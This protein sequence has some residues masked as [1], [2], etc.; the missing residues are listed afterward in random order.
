MGFCLF[1]NV[2]VAAKCAVETM[3][4]QKV[5]IVDWDGIFR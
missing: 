3:K 2:A 4:V 1:N 5:L